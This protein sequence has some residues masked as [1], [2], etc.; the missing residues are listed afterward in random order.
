MTS[1]MCWRVW[2]WWVAWQRT[3]TPGTA[4]LTSSPRS[5]DSRWESMCI[6]FLYQ[7]DV[8]ICDKDFITFDITKLKFWITAQR[9]I[10]LHCL[11]E[12]VQYIGYCLLYIVGR[13]SILLKIIYLGFSHH[14][15]LFTTTC[16]LYFRL[17]RAAWNGKD[18]GCCFLVLGPHTLFL[19]LLAVSHQSVSPFSKSTFY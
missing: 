13:E 19:I 15:A 3:S 14:F 12:H 7:V 4:R 18:L 6:K 17:T 8:Y 5:V 2:R 9:N 1:W 10:L 16:V 11:C